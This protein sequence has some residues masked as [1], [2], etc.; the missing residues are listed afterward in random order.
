MRDWFPRGRSAG[1]GAP[2]PDLRPPI[3]NLREPSELP[4]GYAGRVR[5]VGIIANPSAGKD[6]R[7]LVAHASTFDN[8]EKVNIVRRVLLGLAAIGVDQVLGMPDAFDVVDRALHKLRGA[9]TTELLAFETWDSDR[10]S[11]RAAALLRERGV[12]CIVTLGGDG[13]NRAVAKASGT[14]PLVAISTGTNNV[15]PR[16]LEGTIAGL[17]AG[18]VAS[19]RLDLAAVTRPSLCLEILRDGLP[20]DLALVDVAVCD[21]RFVGSRAVWE[22]AAIRQVVSTSARADVIGLSSIG[23]CLPDVSLGP[24][25]GLAVE[26]GPGGRRVLAPIAPGLVCPV[27]VAAHRRL[28]IGDVADVHASRGVLALDG[29]RELPLRAGERIQIR[30]TDRGPRLVDIGEALRQAVEH[31]ILEPREE[32]WNSHT[33]S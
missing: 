18:A 14:V 19:G 13:T 30:L 27:D 21:E 1:D 10:D 3:S 28:Q 24:D 17:A 2:T 15:F 8:L 20:V 33:S 25:E 5:A 32:S 26:L 23:G 31:D 6:I 16:M 4:S 29:E 9:P 11:T 12:G 22:P 7:R